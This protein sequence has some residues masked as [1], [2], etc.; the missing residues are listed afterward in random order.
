MA[1][2]STEQQSYT[3]ITLPA[4]TCVVIV[5]TEWN[6]SIVDRLEEGCIKILHA[7]KIN[8]SL[9]IVPGAFEIGFAIKCYWENYKYKTGKP[10]AFIALACVLK[11]DTPILNMYVMPLQITLLILI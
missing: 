11:G 10:N 1:L 5:R 6:A 3:G 7:N 4:D 9:L 8:Y 2:S